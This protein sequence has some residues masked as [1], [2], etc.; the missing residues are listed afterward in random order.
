MM[1]FIDFPYICPMNDQ[2]LGN[3][4]LRCNLSMDHTQLEQQIILLKNLA[5]EI[6]W[7]KPFI[8]ETLATKIVQ[9]FAL[10]PENTI[11]IQVSS[12]Y[13][14]EF[15]HQEFSQVIFHWQNGGAAD[16]QW[17]AIA[18]DLVQELI[19]QDSE[20]KQQNLVNKNLSVSKEF[21]ANM[22]G[23]RR[24]DSDFGQSKSSLSLSLSALE[25]V[26]LV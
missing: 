10:N 3:W 12:S 25:H 21:V 1:K 8:I 20:Q 7:F 15:S 19:N 9:D 2:N 4:R 13:Y 17:L 23:M 18:P 26:I 24:N 22:L 14:Q 5:I 6:A 16:A 11:W